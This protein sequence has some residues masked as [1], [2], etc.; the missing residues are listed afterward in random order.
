MS[1]EKLSK[2][3]AEAVEREAAPIPADMEHVSIQRL[4]GSISRAYLIN[5]V[6]SWW[7]DAAPDPVPAGARP[8]Y[9]RAV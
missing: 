3:V 2:L 5:G 7:S 4:D 6:L 9:V 8:L 1:A